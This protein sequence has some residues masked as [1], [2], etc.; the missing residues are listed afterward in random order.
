MTNQKPTM[1]QGQIATAQWLCMMREAYQKIR[2]QFVEKV[3]CGVCEE[4]TQHQVSIS[5]D[6]KMMTCEK[7]GMYKQLGVDH[8]D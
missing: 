5:G 8:E 3:A 6:K 1:S 4:I 2:E 7:C